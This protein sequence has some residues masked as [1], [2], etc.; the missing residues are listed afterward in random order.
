MLVNYIIIAIAATSLIWATITFL[1]IRR[2][3]KI[4]DG[5]I[6]I[7]DHLNRR[8][9]GELSE[10]PGVEPRHLIY[11]PGPKC[12]ICNKP[13]FKFN[14]CKDHYLQLRNQQRGFEP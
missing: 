2:M 14:V 11:S 12:L 6:A 9:L 10:M 8:R 1:L 13:E 4:L 7:I 5:M 3:R